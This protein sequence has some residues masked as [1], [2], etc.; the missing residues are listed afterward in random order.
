M[1]VDD[2]LT[3]HNCQ[4]YDYSRYKTYLDSIYEVID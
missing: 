3:K 1:I 4:D 2:K